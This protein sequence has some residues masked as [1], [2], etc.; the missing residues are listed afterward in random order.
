LIDVDVSVVIHDGKSLAGH[1]RFLRGSGQRFRLEVKTDKFGE[2]A[3]GQGTFPW[4]IAGGR[5]LFK[6]VLEAGPP[7][8][9]PLA[10][11]EPR[12]RDRLRM[13]AGALAA[14]A[15][16]PDVLDQVADIRDT[17]LPGQ[18][19]TLSIVP[20]HKGK[21]LGVIRLALDTDGKSPKSAGFD[22]SGLRGTA[23]IH[24]WQFDALAYDAMFEPPAGLNEKDVRQQD[25]QR[26]MSSLLNFAMENAP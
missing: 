26:M 13:V 7:P 21:E 12:S 2:T 4:M 9:D 14:I 25:L 16:A 3:F 5:T 11:I 1:V 22:V 24:A 20:R 10:F 6:G 17:S 8:V 15:L 19:Q 23:T 18:P